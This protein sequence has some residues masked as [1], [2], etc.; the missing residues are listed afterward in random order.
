MHGRSEAVRGRG[1]GYDHAH[2]AIDDHTHLAYAQV[3]PDEKSTTCAAFPTRAAAFFTAH[4]ITRIHRV[5]TD[6]PPQPPHLGPLPTGLRRTGRPAKFTRPRCPWTHGKAERLNRTLA[7][8]RAYQRPYTN[9]D[10]PTPALPA[11]LKHDNTQH[12]HSARAASHPSPDCH[13]DHD[14]VHLAHHRRPQHPWPYGGTTYS[15]AANVPNAPYLAPPTPTRRALLR[16][17]SVPR[18]PTAP[19][20]ERGQRARRLEGNRPHHH[21]HPAPPRL[22]NPDAGNAA[23]LAI[24]RTNARAPYLH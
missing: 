20:Y 6:N 18:P 11:W 16:A 19:N 4:G 13:Q 2:T 22:L 8:E 21:E 9:N 12:P 7:T 10:Q 24:T 1:I 14:R 5:P 23:A 17:V 3:L 15:G